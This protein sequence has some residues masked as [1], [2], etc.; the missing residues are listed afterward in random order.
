M[1]FLKCLKLDIVV[2]YVDVCSGDKKTKMLL[3]IKN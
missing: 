3:K 2:Y 1:K